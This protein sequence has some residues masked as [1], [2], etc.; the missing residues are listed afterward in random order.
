MSNEEKHDE[1]ADRAQQNARGTDVEQQGTSDDL[2]AGPFTVANEVVDMRLVQVCGVMG[3]AVC[4]VPREGADADWTPATSMA[5][6][7]AQLLNDQQPGKACDTETPVPTAAPGAW[8][9][10]FN[11]GPPEQWTITDEEHDVIPVFDA[12]GKHFTV[13]EAMDCVGGLQG[14][15]ARAT[16]IAECLNRDQHLFERGLVDAKA[17]KEAVGKAVEGLPVLITAARRVAREVETPQALI[18]ALADLE[19]ALEAFD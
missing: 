3:R 10:P 17:A 15:R 7:L 14:A 8:D 4:F 13:V 19:T 6:Y 5:R 12:A 2:W 18:D 1:T 16:R 9:G 11:A